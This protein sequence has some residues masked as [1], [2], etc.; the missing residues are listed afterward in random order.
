MGYTGD[1]VTVDT[2]GAVTGNKDLCTAS[3]FIAVNAHPFFNGAIQPSDSGDFLKSQIE[4]IQSTCGTDKSI[5]IT[6][7][8]WPTQGSNDGTC[9][10]SKENQLTAIKSIIEAGLGDQV[11]MFTTYNDPWKEAGAYGVEQYW[12]IYSS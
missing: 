10:P 9:V 12:G 11:F 4:S 3:D 8:G 1:V 2:V 5:M 6:E 7:T